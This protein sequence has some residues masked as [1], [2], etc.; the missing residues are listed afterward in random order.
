MSSLPRGL[1]PKAQRFQ[2]KSRVCRTAKKNP[3]APKALPQIVLCAARHM[4]NTNLKRRPVSTFTK[5]HLSSSQSLFRYSTKGP[6][7][8]TQSAVG[9]PQVSPAFPACSTSSSTALQVPVPLPAPLPAASPMAQGM[10]QRCQADSQHREF[11]LY[12]SSANP[13]LG[14][15]GLASVSP[16]AIWVLLTKTTGHS[17][18]SKKN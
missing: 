15:A 14:D 3:P 17:G 16:E 18:T 1:P 4:L 2:H 12:P 10:G 7:R 11:T 8:V 13:A 9:V 6:P 5:R